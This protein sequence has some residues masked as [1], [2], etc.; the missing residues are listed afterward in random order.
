MNELS[1]VL[2]TS[3]SAP[4]PWVPIK[5]L[6]PIGISAE[7][8]K[9][10]TRMMF[11]QLC[12]GLCRCFSSKIREYVPQ[13]GNLTAKL[14]GLLQ[15]S[16]KEL[17][18]EIAVD[19]DVSHASHWKTPIPDADGVKRPTT[20]G[21]QQPHVLAHE[22]QSSRKCRVARDPWRGSANEL[23]HRSKSYCSTANDLY[24]DIVVIPHAQ[25]Y[26]PKC[27]SAWNT[28]DVCA[29][30]TCPRPWTSLLPASPRSR[31]VGQHVDSGTPLH[32]A[33]TRPSPWAQQDHELLEKENENRKTLLS[34]TSSASLPTLRKNK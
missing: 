12:S 25:S 32:G 23:N 18:R 16:H 27:Y 17:P 15:T 28:M 14:H 11:H 22:S 9:T 2:R 34:L 13:T 5:P 24:W 26:S 1:A 10:L 4:C 3:Q 8:S 31:Q 29:R 21:K 33:A 7:S 30:P 6:T 19:E 20:A